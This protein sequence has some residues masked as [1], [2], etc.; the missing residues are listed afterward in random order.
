MGPARG[1]FTLQRD[2]KFPLTA[3]SSEVVVVPVGATQSWVIVE[4]RR[5]R[6]GF[7]SS[8]MKASSAK[9]KDK[10]DKKRM[11]PASWFES[12]GRKLSKGP[13][14]KDKKDKNKS[15]KATKAG[16]KSPGSAGVGAGGSAPVPELEP[17]STIVVDNLIMAMSYITANFVLDEGLYRVPGKKDSV[18]MLSKSL[19]Q[20]PISLSVLDGYEANDVCDA[21]KAAMHLCEPVF[22]FDVYDRMLEC[23]KEAAFGAD[24]PIREIADVVKE[25]LPPNHSRL[26]CHL[27]L[28]FRE[29]I[30]KGTGQSTAVSYSRTGIGLALLRPRS[31]DTTALHQITKVYMARNKF[32]Q[33]VLDQYKSLLPGEMLDKASAEAARDEL[34]H[35]I[36]NLLLDHVNDAGGAGSLSVQQIQKHVDQT[37]GARA[38]AQCRREWGSGNGSKVGNG[39][40]AQYVEQKVQE[41][42]EQD[43]GSSEFEDHGG[44]NDP[45]SAVK[46]SESADLAQYASDSAS[47]PPV[48]QSV[49]FAA[50]DSKQHITDS[51][52]KWNR[53]A[54]VVTAEEEKPWERDPD[55]WDTVPSDGDSDEEDE[56]EDARKEPP[57]GYSP[58]RQNSPEA[59]SLAQRSVSP[60]P[61][62]DVPSFAQKTKTRRLSLAEKYEQRTLGRA[63]DSPASSTFPVQNADLKSEAQHQLTARARPKVEHHDESDSSIDSNGGPFSSD[64][65]GP[66]SHRLERFLTP[67]SKDLIQ[68]HSAY[69]PSLS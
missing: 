31:M 17:L 2:V 57:E 41:I 9:A 65:E 45:P 68:V 60:A 21:I 63:P 4:T 61:E 12:I 50:G 18:G 10:K 29:L 62:S 33:T 54:A 49:V 34:R 44:E 11:S 28:H 39:W 23:G 26:F 5:V 35:C 46:R 51:R 67:Q 59:T 66:R 42:I 1:R 6:P 16:T 64:E 43:S 30:D 52:R 37:L 25:R 3:N 7:D 32:F 58:S 15:T 47:E 27:V 14:K 69:R 24:A 48:S 20:H 38:G 56:F 13:D 40:I 8:T 36:D 19:I 53:L 55:N 22:P